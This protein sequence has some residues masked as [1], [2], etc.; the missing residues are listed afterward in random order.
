MIRQDGTK[1]STPVFVAPC[2][3]QLLKHNVFDKI[4]H[5]ARGKVLQ[6]TLQPIHGRSVR[7]GLR[8]GEMERA[9]LLSWGAAALVRERLTLSSDK[10][11]FEVCK[12]CGT[13]AVV[14]LT[15]REK[16]C[17]VCRNPAIEK[18]GTVTC[19][20]I[21]I[22]ISSILEGM[23]ITMKYEVTEADPLLES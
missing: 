11:T 4:Q 9:A 17:V 1:I 3:Y 5:R 2:Y 23:G 19:S 14:N 8:Q 10:Y 16:K 7:G 22:L 21:L 12:T 6:L 13:R 18:I 20:F 15:L